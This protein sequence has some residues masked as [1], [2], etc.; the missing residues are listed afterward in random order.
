MKVGDKIFKGDILDENKMIVI[1]R[2]CHQI[3]ILNAGEEEYGVGDSKRS[4]VK[5]LPE[6]SG[7]DVGYSDFNWYSTSEDSIAFKRGVPYTVVE[8]ECVRCKIIYDTNGGS[9]IE[10]AVEQ[11]KLPK[12]LPMPTNR[13]MY[14]MDGIWTDILQL[15]QHLK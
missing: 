7:H 3:W 10:D 4:Q 14:L 2:T 8:N 5:S 15:L 12:E 11:V 13:D 1:C 6:H 9:K